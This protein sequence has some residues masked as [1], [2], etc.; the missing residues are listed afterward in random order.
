M[1]DEINRRMYGTRRTIIILAFLAPTFL[2]FGLIAGCVYL[3]MSGGIVPTEMRTLAAA[4]M[5]YLYG[6]L[7]G[8]VKDFL[9]VGDIKRDG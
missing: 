6:A 2:S 5:G 8:L 9:T 1:S 7:P 3:Y 4:G